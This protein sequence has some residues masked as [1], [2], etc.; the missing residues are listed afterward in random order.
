M[1]VLIYAYGAISIYF[2]I[3]ALMSGTVHGFSISIL[4][5]LFNIIVLI[6][7]GVLGMFIEDNK[8]SSMIYKIAG[9]SS[10]VYLLGIFTG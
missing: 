2:S 7:T 8:Y 9:V 1:I 10:A 5:I 3:V 6:V 4:F